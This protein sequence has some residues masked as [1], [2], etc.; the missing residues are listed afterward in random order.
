LTGR[1]R[2]CRQLAFEII[3]LA[4][5]ARGRQRRE[6]EVDQ[7]QTVAGFVVEKIFELHVAMD[8]TARV[9]VPNYCEQKFR[10][11]RDGGLW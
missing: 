10:N 11:A 2:G 9:Q 5:G 1:G 8:D 4:F 7:R 3:H 6:P